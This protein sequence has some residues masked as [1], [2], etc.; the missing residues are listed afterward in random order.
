MGLIQ[1]HPTGENLPLS[2]LGLEP[3]NVCQTAVAQIKT[4]MTSSLRVQLRLSQTASP[5]HLRSCQESSRRRERTSFA[6]TGQRWT[7][8]GITWRLWRQTPVSSSVISIFPWVL[9]ARSARKG[10]PSATTKVTPTRPRRITST[11]G[12]L[13]HLDLLQQPSQL[14]PQQQLSLK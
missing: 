7:L 5:F 11:A 12:P 2:A 13:L 1:P 8:K 9:T 4:T 6:T 10:R 3:G 14:P